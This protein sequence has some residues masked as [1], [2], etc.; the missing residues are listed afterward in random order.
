M[1]A[2]NLGEVGEGPIPITG[3]LDETGYPIGRDDLKVAKERTRQLKQAVA[4]LTGERNP[5]PVKPRAPTKSP[6]KTSGEYALSKADYSGARLGGEP[7][8]SQPQSRK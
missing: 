7:A 1:Q 8:D 2:V 5:L 6:S 4:S 3:R